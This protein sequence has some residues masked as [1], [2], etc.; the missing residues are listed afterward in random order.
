MKIPSWILLFVSVL[1]PGFCRTQ[2]T[3]RLTLTEALRLG[4]ERSVDALVARNEYVSAYWEYRTFRTELLPEITLSGTLPYYSKSYNSFQ[5]NDGS[6][7]YVANNYHRID[8]GVSISQNIPWT[9]GKI[10]VESSFEQLHQY[11][12]NGYTSYKSV[13][14]SIILEQPLFGFNRIRWLQRIEPIK[15]HEATRQLT[16]ELEE[17]SLTVL[18]CY[19][20]LLMGRTNLDIA[21]Q[22]LRNAER[23]YRISEAEHRIGRLSEIDLMRMRSSLLSAEAAQS[24]AAISLESRMFTLRSLLGIDEGK[25]LQ[26]ELP[27]FITEQISSL[28]YR[29]VIDLAHQNHPFFQNIQ[30][31]SLEASRDVSQAKAKRHDISLFA[32]F[33]MSGKARVLGRAYDPHDW[34]DDQ[35]IS[36]GISIPILD[37][38]KRKGEVRIAEANRELTLSQIE[39]EKTDFDQ[40]IFLQVQYFNSQPHRLKL[41]EEN[42]ELAVQRYETTVE[43]FIRGKTDILTLNDAQSSKDAALQDCIEQMYRLWDY[44][45]RIRSLTL[46]DFIENK[47]IETKPPEGLF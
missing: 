1:A 34:R 20:D 22:N 12:E 17:V 2:D 46:Y 44:Y 10:T 35:V 25:I 3:L 16:S 11:G 23:L 33:G 21:E 5:N 7:E 32:S 42:A 45:F 9:G 4:Q 18:R 41:A 47:P 28:S 24:E 8:G 29:E 37:W 27:K 13:P 15:Y 30:R 38:G 31:R 36:L 39:K 40:N 43:A 19:F 26:A 14:G 6:W